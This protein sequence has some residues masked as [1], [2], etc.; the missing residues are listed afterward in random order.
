MEFV[1]VLFVVKS[2]KRSILHDREWRNYADSKRKDPNRVQIR[3]LEE[4]SIFKDVDGLGFSN[5]IVSIANELYSDVAKG[6]I[7]RGNCRR[8]IIFACIFHAYKG[9]GQPQ[10]HEKLIK[11]FN[12]KSKV[13]SK[14]LKSM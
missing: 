5:K 10:T 3:K 1:H 6:N 7:Y 12:F 9:A 4:R 8:A 2:F 14:R 11:L 13:K